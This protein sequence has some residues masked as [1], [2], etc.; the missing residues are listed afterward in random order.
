MSFQLPKLNYGY[1]DL[2]PH[3]DA[4]TMKIHHTKHHQGYVDKLNAALEGSDLNS[5][6]IEEILTNL[7]QISEDKKDAIINNGGGH[8][9]HTL[10]WELMT[11]G[12]A[13]QPSGALQEQITKDFGSLDKLIGEVSSTAIA[14][15]GSGWGWLVL[16]Q[17]KNLEVISTPNQNSPLMLGMIP[18]LGID[19]WEHAY[20][21]NY[22][23]RR[24]DYV[25][26][27]WNIVN[28]DIVGQK[29]QKAVH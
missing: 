28:W 17:D 15:F 22:Q 26:A 10:F 25:Q 20:Y 6:P 24:P 18:L 9:N 23:N 29:F 12:G 7:D 13:K 5:K 2:E 27:W 21:L 19:V 8:A 3:I 4:L 14:Q 1:S 11:P 16:D